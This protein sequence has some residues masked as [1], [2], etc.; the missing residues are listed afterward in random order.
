MYD[1]TV[2]LSSSTTLPYPEAA[3]HATHD[4]CGETEG[5]KFNSCKADTM[6]KVVCQDRFSSTILL[7]G[8]GMQGTNEEVSPD[9]SR[10]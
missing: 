2:D 5:N 6:E 7:G 3:G 8:P 1:G 10:C 9:T 4:E